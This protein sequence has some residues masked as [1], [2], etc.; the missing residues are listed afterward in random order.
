MGWDAFPLFYDKR[1]IKIE[2]ID[3]YMKTANVQENKLSRITSDMTIGEVVQ[4]YT[5]VTEVLMDEGVHCVGCGASYYET[6][7]E[8]LAGH[9]RNEEEIAKI[10]EKLNAAIP[11]ESGSADKI[12]ITE[13]AA[14]KLKIILKEQNKE[15]FGLRIQ[16]VKGGCAGFSYNFSIE[17]KSGKE[18]TVLEVNKVKFFLDS[19]SLN[20]LK[21]AKLDYVG[22]LT[23]AG[24]KV[25]NPNAHR[26][27][28]C[29]SSFG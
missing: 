26:T 11:K 9:G 10:I 17:N 1:F 14:D 16:V 12:L 8:G 6:I 18:D 28:G 23:G 20:Q 19:E 27:C 29:G 22:S 5:S 24:F 21:G 2:L 3:D 25:S 15:S 4:K 13:K 7:A